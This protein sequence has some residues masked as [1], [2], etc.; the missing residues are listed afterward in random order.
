M[1]CATNCLFCNEVGTC[2]QCLNGYMLSS[3]LTCVLAC[4]F[5]CATCVNGEPSTC[6]SCLYGFLYSPDSL[7]N[8]VANNTEC[9]NNLNCVYC[10]LGY[11]L[12]TNNSAIAINQTC[13]ACDT[14]CAR[15]M[16][17]NA[18]MCTGCFMGSYLTTL[19][20]CTSCSTGCAACS[21]LN[22]C[23]Y[24]SNGYV[25]VASSNLYYYYSYSYAL[26]CAMCASPCLTC[27]TSPMTCVS[28]ITG[29]SLNGQQWL[30]NFNYQ[31]VVT[32]VG[33]TTNLDVNS[34]L[35]LFVQSIANAANVSASSVTIINIVYAS[36]QITAVISTTLTPGSQAAIDQQNSIQSQVTTGSTL[37]GLQVASTTLSTNGGSNSSGSSGISRTSVII[38]AVVIPVGTLCN[39]III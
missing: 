19:G 39:Y 2:S 24:C 18:T 4:Q 6:T 1:Q 14:N 7:N 32:F 37:G 12:A 29:Y 27:V 28:C 36:I 21:S 31:I 35:S 26:S 20:A 10:G 8:C 13:M 38:L 23:Y 15:C 25:S 11:T 30:S 16:S 3:T 9:N 34:Q 5:P 17:D 22:T 33:N